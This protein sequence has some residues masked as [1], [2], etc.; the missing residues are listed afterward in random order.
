LPILEK[1]VT[2]R[3]RLQENQ[4]AQGTFYCGAYCGFGFHEDGVI[5]GARVA[6]SLGSKWKVDNSRYEFHYEAKNES[7]VYQILFAV[8]LVLLSLVILEF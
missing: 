1:S 8:F 4:G 5:A 2:A 3:K 6:G 7:S